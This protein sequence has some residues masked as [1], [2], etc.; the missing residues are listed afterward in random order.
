MATTEWIIQ[1]LERL[2]AEIKRTP[3]APSNAG[4]GGAPSSVAGGGG[5]WKKAR[6]TFWAVEEKEGPKGPYARAALYVAWRED[7]ED[8]K[9]KMSTI[10]Q[11][12]IRS[13][14]PLV[15]GTHIEYQS[16]KNGQYENVTAIRVTG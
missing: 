4:G 3:L 16:E 7:G 8:C 12:L 9:A 5:G 11:K 13:V 2:V 15:K 1:E 14:D 10:D 6:V